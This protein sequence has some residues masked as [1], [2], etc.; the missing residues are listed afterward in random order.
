MSWPDAEVVIGDEWRRLVLR[1]IRGHESSDV[2]KNDNWASD[3]EED[4]PPPESQG[5]C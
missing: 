3:E 1:G 2:R 5:R 4:R